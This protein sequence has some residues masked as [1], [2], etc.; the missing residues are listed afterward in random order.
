M[1]NIYNAGGE[2]QSPASQPTHGCGE[3]GCPV[4]CSGSKS[5]YSAQGNAPVLARSKTRND[6]P[7]IHTEQAGK[8]RPSCI[9][10]LMMRKWPENHP[11]SIPLRTELS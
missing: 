8:K 6:G 5:Y 1:G 4:Q 2:S 11:C 10:D 7:S 3:G 9:M